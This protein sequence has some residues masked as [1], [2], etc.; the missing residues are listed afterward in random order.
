MS[1]EKSEN[2][3]DVVTTAPKD[4]NEGLL[5]SL[6][7]LVSETHI[8]THCPKVILKNK[9]GDMIALPRPVAFQSPTIQH[10][11]ASSLDK[12]TENGD[13]FDLDL[14]GSILTDVATYLLRSWLI[15]SNT[16]NVPLMDYSPNADS[17]LDLLMAAVYLQLPDLIEISVSK[18]SRFSESNIF[19]EVIGRTKADFTLGVHRF[20]NLWR[21]AETRP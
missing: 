19:L 5:R 13:T 8:L 16:Q 21:S 1:T 11:S 12:F 18:I 10:L 15:R 9:F 6:Q 7:K 14:T 3:I 17:L 4:S 2:S 20:G